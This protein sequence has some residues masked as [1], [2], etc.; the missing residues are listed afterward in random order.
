MRVPPD[1][2]GTLAE[3]AASASSG[4]LRLERARDVGEPRAEQERVHALAR[5][6]HR[7][8]EMQEQPACTR[9]S[10]R[11]YRAAP[12][13]AASWSSAR[14]I[15]VD[16]RAAAPSCWRA[17]CGACRCIWPCGCGASRR[18]RTSSSGS[19]RRLIASLARAISAAVICAKSF[20]CSTSRS[21]T[22]RRA[23]S[24]ISR[25]F[26]LEL[27]LDAGEQRFLHA[28]RAGFGGFG[29]AARRLRQHHRHQLVEIAALAEEDAERLI[30]QHRMLVPLHEHRVQ[31]PV[32][33]LARADAGGLH[34][35]ERI[36]HR[37]GPDRNAG[38]A[39]RAREIDDVLGE[40]AVRL[41]RVDAWQRSLRRAQ[42]RAHLVEQ[43]LG[44]ARLRAA[45]C[46]PGT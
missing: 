40:P 15:E 32:E 18:V 7:V 35:L 38:G 30:E 36:E 22:V 42:L 17:A 19:T 1:Q 21:D 37:A 29:G 9:S 46:R 27:V 13:S 3:Q 26:A 8:Q 11:R 5:I 16:E 44:L 23:S 12:R 10:S 43:L 31:R 34:R 4:S 33:I 28:L 24:S 39:Q 41:A 14:D 2:S 25:S 20:F 45:R 6:G